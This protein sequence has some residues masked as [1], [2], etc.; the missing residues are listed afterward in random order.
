MAVSNHLLDVGAVVQVV[1]VKL[2]H[3]NVEY[4]GVVQA[5]DGDHVV[6]RSVWEGVARDFAF[7]RFEPGDV[8]IEH[9]WRA[10]WYSI[11]EIRTPRGS[12]KGWYCD[13]ARPVRTEP[14]LVISEDLV[15]DLWCSPD[16][17]AVLRL[18][19]DEFEALG[20]GRTDPEASAHALEALDELER[21]AQERF[22]GVL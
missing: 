1:L 7:A 10:R 8:F 14:G 5:D 9:Y 22:A 2:A 20:L 18:D 16:G 4:P 12:L 3:P 13:V 19:E 6:V 21:L 11:K 17:D 15:L